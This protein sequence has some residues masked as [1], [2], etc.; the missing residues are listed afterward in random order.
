MK[1]IKEALKK[2]EKD[3]SLLQA[4]NPSHRLAGWLAGGILSQAKGG[5]EIHQGKA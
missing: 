1:K 5:N 3:P 4:N 2:V